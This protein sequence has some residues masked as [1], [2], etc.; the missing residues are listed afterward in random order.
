[1]YHYKDYYIKEEK[2]FKKYVH[3][4]LRVK[5]NL[6]QISCLHMLLVATFKINYSFDFAHLEG[7]HAFIVPN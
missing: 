3:Q 6:Q 2:A 5:F 1:M 7:E 4:Q